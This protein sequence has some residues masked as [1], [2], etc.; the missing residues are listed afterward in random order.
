MTP[1]ALSL[2]FLRRA[3]FTA[4]VVERF[5]AGVGEHGAG[6][7]RDWGHFADVLACHPRERRILLVQATVLSSLSAR[8]AKSRKQPEL[9]AWLAAGGEFEL[10]GWI[11]RGGRW[12]VKRVAVRGDDMAVEVLERPPCKRRRSRHE[13]GEL[14]ATVEGGFRA[15]AKSG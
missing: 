13:Q 5:I 7:R 9:A 10:H 3:G 4:D 8:V 11:L 2:R 15:D 6:L 1:T 12:R 14:F